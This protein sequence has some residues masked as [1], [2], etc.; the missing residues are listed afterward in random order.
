MRKFTSYKVHKE[1]KHRRVTVQ[2]ST[3][4]IRL[5]KTPDMHNPKVKLQAEEK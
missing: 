2:E 4:R 5:T 1:T 3:N